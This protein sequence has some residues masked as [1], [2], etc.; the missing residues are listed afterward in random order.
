MIRIFKICRPAQIIPGNAV[1]CDEVT[2]DDIS[3][4]NAKRAGEALPPVL[5]CCLLWIKLL[6]PLNKAVIM[7]FFSV[8]K[9]VFMSAD[10]V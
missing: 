2:H 9:E 1:Q 6:K 5:K 3:H 10:A 7:V 4:G 8:L